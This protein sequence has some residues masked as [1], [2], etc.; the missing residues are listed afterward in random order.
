[1]TQILLIEDNQENADMTIRILTSAGYGVEHHLR[2]FA[3][4]QAARS[5]HP[6]VILMDYDLPDIDGRTLSLLLNKQLGQNPPPIIAVT[7]RAGISEMRLAES[8]GCRGFI[9]KPFLPNDLLSIIEEVL[10]SSNG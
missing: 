10:E 7:A 8:F 1:M 9:S 6:D 4:A 3:G 2:G 5:N